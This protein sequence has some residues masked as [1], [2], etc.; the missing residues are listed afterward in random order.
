[1]TY[2]VAFS[3]HDHHARLDD[4]AF[5]EIEHICQRSG[6]TGSGGGRAPAR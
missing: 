3:L 5:V 6:R 2:H 1:M 4:F